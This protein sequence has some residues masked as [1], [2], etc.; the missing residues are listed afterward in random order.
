MTARY[1]RPALAAASILTLPAIAHAQLTESPS[2]D[3]VGAGYLWSNSGEE[4]LSD[5]K[6]Y[7]IAASFEPVDHL[8]FSLATEYATSELDTGLDPSLGDIDLSARALVG[9]VG[10]YW[11]LSDRVHLTVG[12]GVDF[13]RIEVEFQGTS[14]AA[15]LLF[16]NA[17][18]GIN[19]KPSRRLELG[20]SLQR[21]EAINDAAEGESNW[22]PRGNA[23]FAITENIDLITS[24]AYENDEPSAIVGARWR[25]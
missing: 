16:A 19:F 13:E 5:P 10:T 6:G 9:T 3:W 18:V 23:A 8:V 21:L 22:I 12:L 7:A 4:A 14:D 17:E 2:Y 1:L 24:V 11:P 25:F 20:V 15:D